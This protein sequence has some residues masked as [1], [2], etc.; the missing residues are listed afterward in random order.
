M[1]N[2]KYYPL[3]GTLTSCLRYYCADLNWRKVA[4]CILCVTV[5]IVVCDR[6][7]SRRRHIQS[8][9]LLI[10]YF[11]LLICFTLLGRTGVKFEYSIQSIFLTYIKL[12][13]G[14]RYVEYDIIYNIALFIPL[15]IIVREY[16]E[17]KALLFISAA[18]AI[19]EVTQLLFSVGLFEVCDLIDNI[20]GGLIGYVL[21]KLSI[22]AMKKIKDI[23][24]RIKG[25]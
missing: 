3:W 5:I 21:S 4:A 19:I 1:I 9:I 18:T 17:S 13:K 15:G 20:L 24:Q 2:G 11:T 12:F 6:W 14:V 7:K 8:Y 16:P 23:K 10:G 22:H 25:S